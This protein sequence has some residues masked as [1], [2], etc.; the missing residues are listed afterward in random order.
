MC[1]VFVS[2]N[3]TRGGS[4]GR[5]NTRRPRPAL[6]TSHSLLGASSGKLALPSFLLL[7]LLLSSCSVQH[8]SRS[9]HLPLIRASSAGARPSVPIVLYPDVLADGFFSTDVSQVE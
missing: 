6:C 2:R 3:H 4:E 5:R 7:L 1:C 9:S 8:S